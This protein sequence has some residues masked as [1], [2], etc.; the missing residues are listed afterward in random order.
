MKD[1]DILLQMV[2]FSGQMGILDGQPRTLFRMLNAILY[3]ENF[4]T[5]IACDRLI[6]SGKIKSDISEY[7]PVLPEIMHA[8]GS[9]RKYSGILVGGWANN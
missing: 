1:L 7:F 3:C 2:T 9:C 5:R 4:F 8:G 6:L